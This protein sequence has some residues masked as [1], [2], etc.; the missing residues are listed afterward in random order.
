[1]VFVD[2]FTLKEIKKKRRLAM[3]SLTDATGQAV[4][5]HDKSSLAQS[6]IVLFGENC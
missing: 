1:M 2:R 3:E 4:V 5:L 6:P